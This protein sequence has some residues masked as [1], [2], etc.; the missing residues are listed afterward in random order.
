[1]LVVDEFFG[2]RINS[3]LGAEAFHPP[4]AADQVLYI[5]N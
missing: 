2:I 4:D 5:L 1:M 3:H